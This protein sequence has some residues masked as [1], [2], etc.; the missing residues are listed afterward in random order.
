MIFQY[1]LVFVIIFYIIIWAFIKIKYPFWNN[2]PVFHTYDYIRSCYRE[3][4]IIQHNGP[5]KT[6][7]FNDILIKTRHVDE[8]S[9]TIKEITDLLQ[10]HYLSSE[11]IDYIIQPKDIHAILTGQNQP[12]FISTYK[13]PNYE[14]KPTENNAGIELISKEKLV[15]C[16]TSRSV[17]MYLRSVQKENTYN[18]VLMYFIDN[19]CVHREHDH[20]K[21]SRNLLQTHDFNQR[22]YNKKI[23]CSLIKKDGEPF[24]GIRP[25][26]AYNTY[27]YTI[28]NKKVARMNPKYTV[29]EMRTNNMEI[30]IDF[31]TVNKVFETK[32]MLFDIMVLTDLGNI[33][34]Q[35]KEKLLY[36]YYLQRDEDILGFYFIKDMKR[37]YDEKEAKTLSLTCSVQNSNDNNLFYMGFLHVLRQIIHINADYKMITIEDI[38]HNQILHQYW[39]RGKKSLY[40]I[41]SAYYSYNY[42]YPSS[43][44][45]STRCFL[46][47]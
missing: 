43:P 10:C 35:I 41:E 19:L 32:T 13:L 26:I 17:T 38:G 7:Y 46:L 40:S 1:I 23:S 3:P 27:F 39:S 20:I 45:N 33:I 22:M 2:Q 18:K 9:Q 25:L 4:F 30:F 24:S 16:I 28:P 5:Y 29:K 42:V 31:F 6:K 36:V 34:S 15:G 44:I 37:H 14:L 12:S 11:Y 8:C 47:F 21:I